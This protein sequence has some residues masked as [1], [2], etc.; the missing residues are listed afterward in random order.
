M[1][2]YRS[3]RWFSIVGSLLLRA[4]ATG[5]QPLHWFHK[6]NYHSSHLNS[7][8]LDGQMLKK[9]RLVFH[10][11]ICKLLLSRYKRLL[12]NSHAV[13]EQADLHHLLKCPVSSVLQKPHLTGLEREHFIMLHVRFC[14]IINYRHI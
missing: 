11:H 8:N 5:T 14:F 4:P 6:R 13:T 1:R 9:V 2:S 10:K 3:F 12:R 7:I